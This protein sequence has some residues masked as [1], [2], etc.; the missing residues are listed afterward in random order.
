VS[1]TTPDVLKAVGLAQLILAGLVFFSGTI[2]RK[3]GNGRKGIA[4]SGALV[5]LAPFIAFFFLQTYVDV[6]FW[7]LLADLVIIAVIIGMTGG[8]EVS[9]FVP[10]YA[11]L[12]TYAVVLGEPLLRVAV[13]YGAALAL[14]IVTFHLCEYDWNVFQTSGNKIA[15]F[16]VTLVAF[17]VTY[18]LDWRTHDANEIIRHE[19][20]EVRSKYEVGKSL[21]QLYEE[22]AAVDYDKQHKILS[23]LLGKHVTWTV[24]FNN[25]YTFGESKTPDPKTLKF[26]I[27]PPTSRG[28]SVLYG[29]QAVDLHQIRSYP[30]DL[31]R[32]QAYEVEGILVQD[33]YSDLSVLAIAGRSP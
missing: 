9:C 26:A 27:R 30:P 29:I 32:G 19:L 22:L 1:P 11:M 23:E 20:S 18:F 12:P 13:L 4:T 21:E 31:E 2:L 15:L 33:G 24:R 16:M 17:G 8:S 10:L 6:I 7:G 28:Q 3:W 5:C 25:W 14:F